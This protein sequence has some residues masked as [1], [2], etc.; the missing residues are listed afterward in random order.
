MKKH[1]FLFLALFVLGNAFGVVG[2]IPYMQDDGVNGF[3]E[4]KIVPPAEITYMRF[5]ALGGLALRTIAQVKEEL[6]LGTAAYQSTT[7][8]EPAGAVSTFQ[9]ALTEVGSFIQVDSARTA[10]TATTATIAGYANSAVTADFATTARDYIGGGN[11]ES[12]LGD[13]ADRGTTLAEYGITDAETVGAAVLLKQDVENGTVKAASAGG[14]DNATTAGYATTAG[15]SETAG[16]AYFATTALEYAAGGSIESAINAKANSSDLG[17]LATQNGTIADYALN[18][19]LA[20][21]TTTA[22]LKPLATTTINGTA[23]ATT[24]LRGDYTWATV[25]EGSGSGDAL[26]AGNQTWTGTNNFADITVK[27]IATTEPTT[28]VLDV[29][30]VSV[31][32]TTLTIP[33]NANIIEVSSGAAQT[34]SNFVGAVSGA[35]Y[36]IR[37]V[38]QYTITFSSG[39]NFTTTPTVPNLVVLPGYVIEIMGYGLDGRVV[40]SAIG[41]SQSGDDMLT[42]AQYFGDGIDGDVII[43]N[44]TTT[45]VRD[46]FYRN[47]TVNGT[48]QLITS[49]F[50]VFVSGIL[51]IAA[52]PTGAITSRSASFGLGGNG[53]ANGT[54][55]SVGAAQSSGTIMGAS[56]GTVGGTGSITIGGNG[57]TPTALNLLTANAVV[58]VSAIGANGGNGTAG[59]GGIA[60]VSKAN[61]SCPDRIPSISTAVRGTS[62]YFAG[63]GGGGGAGG[64]GDGGIS[65]GGGGGG[66][67]SGGF[68]LIAANTIHRGLNTNEGIMQVV[69]KSGGRGGSPASGASGGGGGG[70]GGSGGGI[71]LLYR[72]LTGAVITNAIEYSGG[73][74]GNGGNGTSTGTG[75]GGGSSG[76]AGFS[77]LWDISSGS[78]TWSQGS[79]GSAGSAA[80]GATGGSGAAINTQKTSL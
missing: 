27:S 1:I 31:N 58:Y 18:S 43:S 20:N 66:G 76:D 35:K 2:D 17:T 15:S 7:A 69:G 5:D 33:A 16:S 10:N 74:G 8:F 55:G 41:G 54:G 34:I 50:R 62:F 61:V 9:T 24:Y 70:G 68:L 60:S 53:N 30:S 52:A 36:T 79:A 21:Y 37:N 13:K 80:S 32:S 19:T 40:M 65:G 12:A 51:D 77:M 57:T 56:G 11:I 45:L 6:G 42:N 25:A 3:V 38:G 75:G 44:G 71:R 22:N 73:A 48:G 59:V 29:A 14:A 64:G 67:A 78:C 72:A 39:A 49:G 4:K 26:L 63:I 47:L 28:Q 23:S 46:M